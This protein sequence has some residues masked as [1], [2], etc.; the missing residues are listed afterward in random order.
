MA[1]KLTDGRK[2]FT[3]YINTC[4]QETGSHIIRK[5]LE[6]FPYLPLPDVDPYVKVAGY[7]VTDH[8]LPLLFN[9]L[10][11][12]KSCL[13]LP[14]SDSPERGTES[15]VDYMY[16]MNFWARDVIEG[17]QTSSDALVQR[18]TAFNP[19]FRFPTLDHRYEAKG[20]MRE[21]FVG[22]ARDIRFTGSYAGKLI[23]QVEAL[24]EAGEL[25]PVER[26]SE[27]TV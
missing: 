20:V 13:V 14:E 23:S 21:R 11:L 19:I 12:G 26:L 1:E 16:F 4:L 22:E 6:P 7:A 27:I 24:K 10:V 15:D 17:E 2:E 9:E 5:E 18:L 3:D 8:G 25:K